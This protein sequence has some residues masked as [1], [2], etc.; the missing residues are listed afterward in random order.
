MGGALLNDEIAAF[1]EQ[2]GGSSDLLERGD[3]P[4]GAFRVAGSFSLN[5]GYQDGSVLAIRA[6]PTLN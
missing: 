3:S 4:E 5:W 1:H 6:N 2:P